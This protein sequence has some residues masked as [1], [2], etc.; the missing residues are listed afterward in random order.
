MVGI[1]AR[2]LS[3]ATRPA[4]AILQSLTSVVFEGE[5][6]GVKTAKKEILEAVNRLRALREG[7]PLA[8][9]LTAD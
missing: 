9:P 7:R 8:V 5:A 1:A 3:G 6:P 2:L 4:A